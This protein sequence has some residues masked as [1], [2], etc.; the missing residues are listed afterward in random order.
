MYG[1]SAGEVSSQKEDRVETSEV[2]LQL[3]KFLH[4]PD[5]GERPASVI[6]GLESKFQIVKSC[7]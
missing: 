6:N 7:I 3:D 2:F 4:V 1:W 5:K